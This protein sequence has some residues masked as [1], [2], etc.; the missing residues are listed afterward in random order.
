LFLDL[1]WGQ[2]PARSAPAQTPAPDERAIPRNPVILDAPDIRTIPVGTGRSDR[3]ITRDILLTALLD[4]VRVERSNGARAGDRAVGDEIAL[5]VLAARADVAEGNQAA[6]LGA[7]SDGDSQSADS[8]SQSPD[9]VASLSLATGF[10]ALVLGTWR[11]RSR[12]RRSVLGEK[13]GQE[14]RE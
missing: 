10:K 2:D 4:E 5:D 13:T 6:L 7:E 8:D 9:L 11:G 12:P 14:P 1:P 3:V